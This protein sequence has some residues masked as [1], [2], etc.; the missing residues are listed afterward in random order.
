MTTIFD[1]FRILAAGN[2]EAIE[3]I[4]LLE[5]EPLGMSEKRALAYRVWVLIIPPAPKGRQHIKD[6][7]WGKASAKC[8]YWGLFGHKPEAAA[9]WMRE[10]RTDK[11]IAHF[12]PVAYLPQPRT[13]K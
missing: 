1:E 13:G 3:L 8:I 10:N 4:D 11:K 12:Q 5:N 6:S 2:S 7:Y 9:K